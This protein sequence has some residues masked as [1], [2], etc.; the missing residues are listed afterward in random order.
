MEQEQIKSGGGERIM[1]KEEQ[2]KLRKKS[3]GMM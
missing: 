3:D 1:S 2:R